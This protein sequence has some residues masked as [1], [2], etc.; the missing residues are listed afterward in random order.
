MSEFWP[1]LAILAGFFSGIIALFE[2]KL[3][4]IEHALAYTASITFIVTVFSFMLLPFAN[5][6]IIPLNWILLYAYSITLTIS[7]WFTARLFRHGN[8]SIASPIYKTLPILFVVIFAFLF[9]NESLTL[10]QYG[11]IIILAISAYL[12]INESKKIKESNNYKYNYRLLILLDTLAVSFGLIILKYLLNYV[13]IASIIIIVNIFTSLNLMAIIVRRGS[14]YLS[15]FKNDIKIYINNIVLISTLTFFY[16]IIFYLT[17]SSI[18]ISLAIPIANI[19]TIIITV[20]IGGVIFKEKSLFKKV[21][22]ALIM[23][24]SAYF[25]IVT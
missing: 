24:V 11:F 12:L 1:Y 6:N 2:K 9:L 10:I 13:N 7:F 17:I 23:I 21:L 5:F 19:T 3:L 8:I 25:L 16:R 18:L 14:T 22:L 20:L 4:K 15:W